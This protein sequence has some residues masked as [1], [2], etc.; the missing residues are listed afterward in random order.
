MYVR[1]KKKQ[2]VYNDFIDR[3]SSCTHTLNLEHPARRV[4][5]NMV[6]Q[7]HYWPIEK[8]FSNIPTYVYAVVVQYKWFK[9]TRAV[10]AV[11]LYKKYLGIRYDFWL[12][13]Y[14][15]KIFRNK[16]KTIKIWLKGHEFKNR[17]FNAL[18]LRNLLIKVYKSCK[19]L[20]KIKILIISRTRKYLGTFKLYILLSLMN[21]TI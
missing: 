17:N 11:E 14:P 15:V 3:F 20:L 8:P 16:C 10:C 2:T 6:M 13:I 19:L 7:M 18:T 21:D 5:N 12:D 9:C 4:L 1:V